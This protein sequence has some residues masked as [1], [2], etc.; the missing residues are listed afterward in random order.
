MP[1]SGYCPEKIPAKIGTTDSRYREIT[2]GQLSF[3]QPDE[4]VVDINDL[5]VEINTFV[6]AHAP[7]DMPLGK[8]DDLACEIFGLFIAAR[9]EYGRKVA[10]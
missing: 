5:K 7:A 10:A 6:W 8:A 3:D 9:D 4:N 2:T 1:P